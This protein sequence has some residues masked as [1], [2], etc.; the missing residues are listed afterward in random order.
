RTEYFS[1]TAWPPAENFFLWQDTEQ[2]AKEA[3]KQVMPNGLIQHSGKECRHWSGR[4]SRFRD[5]L[6][7]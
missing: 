1:Q 5:A 3:G 2:S 7:I 6:K 4:H